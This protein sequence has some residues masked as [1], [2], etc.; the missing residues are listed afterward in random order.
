MSLDQNQKTNLDNNE[1]GTSF[2]EI[3]LNAEMLRV[4]TF[5]QLK[6]I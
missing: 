6:Q 1:T 5:Q 2:N 4:R 3:R